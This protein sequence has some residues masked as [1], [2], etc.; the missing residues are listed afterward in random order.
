M[1]GSRDWP[2][3]TITSEAQSLHAADLPARRGI[4]LMQPKR[5]AIVLG[6]SQRDD[7]VDRDFCSAHGI[8]VVRRRSGGGAVYV[9]PVASVWIDIVIPRADALW[10]DDVGRAMHFVG[11][12]WREVLNDLGMDGLVINEGAHVANDWSRSLCVAGR[13]TGEVFVGSGAKVVGISQ[14][15]T[16]DFAR[17][18]CIAYFAWDVP[19]HLGAIPLLKGDPGRVATL[20]APVPA[21]APVE[22]VSRLAGVTPSR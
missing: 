4:W 7:D 13:G 6:S 11:R 5:P 14:R 18:Q 2:T 19:T 16:R 12:A 17:F 21:V 22:L 10:V 20:V 9:D 8:D 3:E 1:N 15:R